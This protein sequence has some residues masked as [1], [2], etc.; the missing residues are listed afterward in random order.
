MIESGRAQKF[1]MCLMSIFLKAR[2]DGRC[3]SQRVLSEGG[4]ADENISFGQD[5]VHKAVSE[6]CVPGRCLPFF[7]QFFSVL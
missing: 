5:T 2:I 1:L 6:F 7:V 3:Y 4:P